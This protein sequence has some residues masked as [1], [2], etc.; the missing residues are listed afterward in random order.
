M[1][2]K[3]SERGIN[4]YIGI[5]LGGT[6][7]AA[8]CTDDNGKLLSKASLPTMSGRSY[9]EIVK[10]MASLCEKVASGASADMSG[11]K[12]IGIGSPGT[13]DSK[14]GVVVYA[15]NLRMEKAPMA[16]ELRKYFDIP[17]FM[18]N[19]ANAAAYGEYTACGH[20]TD[21][22]VFITLGTGVG[23]GIIIDNKIYRGFNGAGAEIGHMTLKM[24]G[25]RCTCGKR[26][27]FERYAS[28]TALRRMTEEAIKEN[29]SSKMCE[30][31]KRRGH[32]SGRTAFECAA[33]GDAAAIKTRDK[34]IRHV[35]EGILSVVNIFQP[36][37]L[38]I[39]GGISKEGDV[40]LKPIKEFV[41]KRDF[42]KFMPRTDI[43]IAKL[44]NDAGI[45]GAAMSAKLR[46][47]E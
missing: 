38:V 16:Q 14:K 28:V 15:G 34:Y 10:D 4:V 26:G 45:V 42:N 5:D 32:V 33:E 40:L 36:E 39:G 23:G 1:W 11:I 27:C 43:R 31:V 2:Q 24:N 9:K 37:I 46:L 6:N 18:E 41:E 22:F 8:G 44:F 35:A 13:I 47:L 29:P 30:W 20:N 25:I 21:S 19:D 12:A 3:I 17:V 7:I